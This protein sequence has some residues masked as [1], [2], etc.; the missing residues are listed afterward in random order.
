MINNNIQIET[1]DQ[2]RMTV[3]SMLQQASHCIDIFSQNLEP[4]ILN[5]KEVEHSILR[6]AKKHPNTQI[7]ILVQDSD[8]AVHNGHCL[9]R[10][11][12]TLT[13]SIFIHTPSAQYKDESH[14]FIL[15]DR[16]AFIHRVSASNRNYNATASFHAPRDTAK[17]I[18]LFDQIWDHSS[19][20]SQTRRLYI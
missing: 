8:N 2:Y 17:L 16:T 20:D 18:E 13:S 3:L 1:P 9:I 7:R 12:Q 4:E 11:A 19:R 15:V 5:S 14:S 6:L 10:L